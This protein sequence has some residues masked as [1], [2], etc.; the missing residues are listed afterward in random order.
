MAR[1][2]WA[3]E[4]KQVLNISETLHGT[5]EKKILT[6]FFYRRH[7]LTVDLPGTRYLLTSMFYV[8]FILVNILPK[9]MKLVLLIIF[10][11]YI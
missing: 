7:T 11:I 10:L 4:K 3:Y 8:K 9:N 6:C 2:E 1:K 5:K